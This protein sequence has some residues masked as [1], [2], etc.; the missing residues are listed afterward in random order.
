MADVLDLLPIKELQNAKCNVQRANWKGSGSWDPAS[1]GAKQDHRNN[2]VVAAID[3][4]KEE[5]PSSLSRF[6]PTELK[7]LRAHHWLLAPTYFIILA[8]KPA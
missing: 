5:H 2:G 6:M 1:L 3:I 8:T 7:G 4:M